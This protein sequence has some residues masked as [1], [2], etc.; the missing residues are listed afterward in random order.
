MLDFKGK[1]GFVPVL[2]LS[3]G[4]GM[5]TPGKRTPNYPD[6]HFVRENEFNRAVIDLIKKDAERL[7]FK[8]LLV[9][10]GDV[11]VPLQKRTDT[12]NEAYRSYQ[13]LLGKKIIVGIYYSQHYN[14]LLGTWE[15]TA[16]GLE[17]LYC[18]GSVEGKKLAAAVNKYISQGTKQVNRGIKERDNLWELNQTAMPAVLNEAGF[19]DDEREAALM[20]DPAFRRETAKQALQGICE[21]FGLTY[22]EEKVQKLYKVQVGPMSKEVADTLS[23]D[24]KIQGYACTVVSE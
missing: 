14:A 15:S 21:Y 20:V 13:K 22:E 23:A 10:P 17:T 5:E 2:F 19:M 11:N 24:L 8:T 12:A 7:G 6:G 4:H 1:L 18:K 3:D 9:A 16:E